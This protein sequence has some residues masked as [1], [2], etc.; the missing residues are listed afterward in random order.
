MDF[1]KNSIPVKPVHHLR[2]EKSVS[3]GVLPMKEELREDDARE[4]IVAVFPRKALWHLHE[5]AAHIAQVLQQE[6]ISAAIG[7]KFS[8]MSILRPL[9]DEINPVKEGHVLVAAGVCRSVENR[10]AWEF[11]NTTTFGLGRVLIATP[12]DQPVRFQRDEQRRA[13]KIPSELVRHIQHFIAGS[14]REF[15][16]ECQRSSRTV[17]VRVCREDSNAEFQTSMRLAQGTDQLLL[18]KRG[19]DLGSRPGRLESL[20][21]VWPPQP[22]MDIVVEHSRFC[23]R[24]VFYSSH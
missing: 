1:G 12:S 16:Y 10:L 14:P 15:A 4:K 7:W 6:R 21:A 5:S 18:R 8:G 24:A 22:V 2:A 11:T 9:R 3:I 13:G 20:F 19:T 23:S 17:G